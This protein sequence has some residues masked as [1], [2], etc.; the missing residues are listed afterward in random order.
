[1]LNTKGVDENGWCYPNL[2]TA[3]VT[4]AVLTDN[5]DHLYSRHITTEARKEMTGAKKAGAK[6]KILKLL[7][8]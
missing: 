7:R 6:K 1:M 5:R 8:E 2:R 4:T 3:F